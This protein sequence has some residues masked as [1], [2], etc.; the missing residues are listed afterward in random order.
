MWSTNFFEV[1]G[2]EVIGNA[3]FEDVDSAAAAFRQSGAAIAVICSS[4]KIYPDVV[5]Q[6]AAT[7][8]QSGASSVVLA[9]NPGDNEQ[10]WRD[11][12]VDRFIFVKCNVLETLRELLQSQ[13]VLENQESSP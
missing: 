10:A 3:G 5:P 13:G 4:D 2:F 6:A 1:G 8:K 9:G 11:A 7:L 12:G